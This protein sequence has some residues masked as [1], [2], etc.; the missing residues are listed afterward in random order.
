M[1]VDLNN[2]LYHIFDG[3]KLKHMLTP[4]KSTFGGSFMADG[5]VVSFGVESKAKHDEDG[6]R[7]KNAPMM[8]KVNEICKG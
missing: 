6:L 4:M 8:R 7:F 1:H 3:N 5:T 2:I